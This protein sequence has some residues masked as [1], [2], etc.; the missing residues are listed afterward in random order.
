[1]NLNL[2]KEIRQ[3]RQ[4]AKK[5]LVESKRIIKTMESWLNSPNEHKIEM[6]SSFFQIFKYHIEEGDLHP[7]NINLAALLRK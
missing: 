3:K 1:M 5:C 7:D 4:E 2:P 6:A